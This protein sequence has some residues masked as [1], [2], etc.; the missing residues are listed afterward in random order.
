[1]Y[2]I[3]KLFE[4][5]SFLKVIFSSYWT[6]LTIKVQFIFVLAMSTYLGL[7]TTC[8]R[9]APMFSAWTVTKKVITL[10]LH[11]IWFLSFCQKLVCFH[12][13]Y[14]GEAQAR[15]HTC[16]IHLINRSKQFKFIYLLWGVHQGGA[17]ECLETECPGDRVPS[18]RVPSGH[19]VPS[20]PILIE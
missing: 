2:L 3:L 18:D 19:Q 10:K 11:Y 7:V 9:L 17:T 4:Y 8:P 1:M 14:L 6:I 16:K 5:S 13:I 15:T 12:V 20:D